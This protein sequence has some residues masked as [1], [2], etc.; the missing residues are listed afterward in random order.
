MPNGDGNVTQQIVVTGVDLTQN[1]VLT[2]VEIINNLL[3]NNQLITD[4]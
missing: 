3:N 1:N 2:D 4:L